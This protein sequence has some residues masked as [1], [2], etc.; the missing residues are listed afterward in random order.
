MAYKKS[1][2]L[3]EKH[4]WLEQAQT[5]VQ[6]ELKKPERYGALE[7][8]AA[9]V[10]GQHLLQWDPRCPQ[11]KM[12]KIELSADK[13]RQGISIKISLAV[14]YGVVK[15][16]SFEKF[17]LAPDWRETED[18]EH[19]TQFYLDSLETMMRKAAESVIQQISPE[20]I[21]DPQKLSWNSVVFS[22]LARQLLKKDDDLRRMMQ[23]TQD[24]WNASY[25]ER[26]GGISCPEGFTLLKI[27]TFEVTCSAS[28]Y[29]G[30]H[31]TLKTVLAGGWY[32][33][34]EESFPLEQSPFYTTEQAKKDFL[35]AAIQKCLKVLMPTDN[36]FPAVYAARSLQAIPGMPAGVVTLLKKGA[37]TL[38]P[39]SLRWRERLYTKGTLFWQPEKDKKTLRYCRGG[40]NLEDCRVLALKVMDLHLPTVPLNQIRRL[41]ADLLGVFRLAEAFQE[42]LQTVFQTQGKKVP[43]V[44]IEVD[45]Q[46][47][48]MIRSGLVY[49]VF[50]SKKEYIGEALQEVLQ[51]LIDDIL[52]DAIRQEVQSVP[53]LAVL[54]TLTAKELTVL[55]Y[56]AKHPHTLTDEASEALGMDYLEVD[57]ILEKLSKVQVPLGNCERPLLEGAWYQVGRRSRRGY[58]FNKIDPDLLKI[59]G[60]KNTKKE[61]S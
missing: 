53:Q 46:M 11:P 10:V 16:W 19:L 35:K 39:V 55:R 41:P 37:F 34:R 17:Y 48:L 1:V 33:Q 60:R 30:G 45:K 57:L 3:V 2:P 50:L 4:R 9:E 58:T 21:L 28:S 54:N 13:E 59:A 40:N 47:Q 31:C 32:W 7:Q 24:A 22:D 51:Q 56:V 44:I 43:A 12:E 15:R 52:K 49:R 26:N 29:D 36:P 6:A 42:A 27:K 38:G 61:E 23:E 14:D 25:D 20:K 18:A 5:A 8:I